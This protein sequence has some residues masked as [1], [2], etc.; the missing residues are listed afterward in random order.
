MSG[1]GTSRAVADDLSGNDRVPAAPGA[2]PASPNH[3][4]IG[5]NRSLSMR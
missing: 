1:T 3:V 4:K 2:P 5:T